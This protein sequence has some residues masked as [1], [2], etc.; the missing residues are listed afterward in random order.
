MPNVLIEP[1][2]S[3]INDQVRERVQLDVQAIDL[4]KSIHNIYAPIYFVCSKEDSFVPCE[5][6]EQLHA[7]Y[8]G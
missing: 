2:L 5:H 6:S 8:N 1:A 4:S 3:L 7:R